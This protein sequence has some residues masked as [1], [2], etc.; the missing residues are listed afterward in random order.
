M[1]AAPETRYA[2]TEDG[3]S[4]AYQTLGD[5]PVDLVLELESWGNVE[6]MWELAAFAELFEGLSAFSRL[7]LHDPRGTGLSG[8]RGSSYP[9]LETRARDLLT[10]LD[11]IRSS[12]AVLFGERTAGAAFA[13]FAATYPDRVSSLVWCRGVATRRWSPEYPWGSTPDEHRQDAAETRDGMGS[14]RL[15]REWLAGSAPSYAGDERLEAEVARL[16]R[17]FMAPSTSAD[18]IAVESETDVT[19]VLPL[20]RC[21]TL[22]LDYERSS[23][24]AAES[25]HVHAMIPGAELS[26]LSEDPP[27]ALPFGSR[28]E[29]CDLVRAFVARERRTEA[30]DTVLGTVLFTDIVGSTERQA[31]MGDR[32][33]GD[34]VAR[35]HAVVREALER[36]RGVENDTAGDG[37]YATFDGPARAIRCAFEVVDRVRELGIEVR[38]GAHTGECEI[39]DGKHAGLAVAI[40]SRIAASAGPSE[41]LVSRTV[42]DLTAGS[43][44]SF[45]DRGEHDLKGVPDR[46]QLYRVVA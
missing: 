24:G 40:G 7:V 44:F 46:W 30:P 10:V 19:A 28:A 6:I 45:E 34:L 18:W 4:I 14:E 27:N 37:F 35:H 11:A 22:L 33:W 38:A 17:H 3:V 26:L 5:G 32:A 21:P 12:R 9:N 43:G 36:W 39:I 8:A 23:T 16:D 13:V 25:R 29:I 15:A 1:T 31:S 41:V 20:L 42:K 2:T